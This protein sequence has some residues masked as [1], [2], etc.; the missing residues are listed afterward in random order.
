MVEGNENKLEQEVEKD[1]TPMG[2]IIRMKY[3]ATMSRNLRFLREQ[4]GMSRRALARR[5][6]RNERF[7]AA[8]EDVKEQKLPSLITLTRLC[9]EFELTPNDL[10]LKD[11]TYP[12][13]QAPYKII[14]LI[15]WYSF[16]T[17][18]RKIQ[19]HSSDNS[20]LEVE[21]VGPR[22][23]EITYNNHALLNPA[24]SVD[25]LMSF[26]DIFG[27]EKSLENFVEQPVTAYYHLTSLAALHRRIKE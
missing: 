11:L 7:L 10:L 2:R 5:I 24:Q 14:G 18:L 22:E 15:G 8:L 16:D 26:A 6:G 12:I 9:N 25:F 4:K 20:Q 17:K 3:M 1:Y 13:L 27:R 21:V 19:W 23:R